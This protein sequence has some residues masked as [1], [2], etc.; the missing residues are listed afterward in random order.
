MCDAFAVNLGAA[1]DEWDRHSSD[2]LSVT[3]RLEVGVLLDDNISDLPKEGFADYFKSAVVRQ[4]LP[5]YMFCVL[6]L[7]IRNTAQ[8]SENTARREWKG[9]RF[10]Q[11]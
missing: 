11:R 2:I 8:T 7:W 3:L 10:L 5:H 9:K 4:K 6:Y 1:Y